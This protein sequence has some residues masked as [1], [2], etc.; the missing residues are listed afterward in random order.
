MANRDTDHELLNLASDIQEQLLVLPLHQVAS[1][2]VVERHIRRLYL[3]LTG[4]N[5]GGDGT[6]KRGA[7][8]CFPSTAILRFTG[9]LDR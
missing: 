9:Q 7:E 8:Q 6:L 2:P 5:S 3:P 4:M 1:Q